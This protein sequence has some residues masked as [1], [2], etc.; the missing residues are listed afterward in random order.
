MYFE[1]LGALLS[2]GTLYPRCHPSLFVSIRYCAFLK[3]IHR[4][5]NTGDLRNFERRM[6]LFCLHFLTRLYLW[7]VNTLKNHRSVL[8]VR[9]WETCSNIISSEIFSFVESDGEGPTSKLELKLGQTVKNGTCKL[10]CR[11]NATSQSWKVTCTTQ[12]V[13]A[14]LESFRTLPAVVNVLRLVEFK[15]IP[16][17]PFLAAFHHD[18]T[19][20]ASS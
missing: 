6:F 14:Q 13:R 4:N 20:A 2:S 17:S 3:F 7:K 11:S 9:D 1:G 10:L 16:Q 5:T 15:T 19:P 12:I 8:M 18:A